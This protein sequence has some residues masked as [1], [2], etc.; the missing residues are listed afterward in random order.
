MYKLF[1]VSS[2]DPQIRI[3]PSAIGSPKAPAEVKVFSKLSN[4]SILIDT[5]FKALGFR[6]GPWS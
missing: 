5:V 3:R 6:C 2:S 4:E 1:A